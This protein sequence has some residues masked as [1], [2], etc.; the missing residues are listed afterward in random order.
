[1]PVSLALLMAFTAAV[2]TLSVCA[3]LWRKRAPETSSAAL[4][5]AAL[6]EPAAPPY[7]PPAGSLLAAQLEVGQTFY[8]QTQTARYV[9]K[10]RDPVHGEYEALR[11]GP[12]PSGEIAEERFIMF[13]AGT[14]VPDHGLLF[15]QFVPGGSLSYKKL[16][17]ASVLEM[18][19]SSRIVRVFFSIPE[20]RQQ[21]S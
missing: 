9:L 3:V 8:V 20:L 2:L 14:H 18:G 4:D 7:A 5:V 12:K 13:F 6:P 21:A 15:G 10:L 16:R 19:Y 1:M 17:D 11:V